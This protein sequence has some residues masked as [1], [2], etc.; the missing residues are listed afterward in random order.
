L[1][2]PEATPNSEPSWFGFPLVVK[3]NSGVQ[4]SDLINFLDQNKI[5]TRLL[6]AGNLTKQPYMAGRNFRVS[7]DLTNT[8]IV[9]NQT[10][11]VGTYPG[12]N[13][14][15]LDYIACKLEEFFG[16]NF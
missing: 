15:H 8:D 14:E 1:H 16:V 9:M 13:E 5:G 11:W 12:L 10:F 4:R 7:G 3:E 2:L 6:F